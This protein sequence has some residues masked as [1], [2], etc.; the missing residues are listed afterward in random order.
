MKHICTAYSS[1]FYGTE[2][3]FRIVKRLERKGKPLRRG[4][5]LT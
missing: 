5:V 1:N 4:V 2:G 3:V